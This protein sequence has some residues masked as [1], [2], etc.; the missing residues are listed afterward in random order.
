MIKKQSGID[1]S[2]TGKLSLSSRTDCKSVS[3]TAHKSAGTFKFKLGNGMVLKVA[4]TDKTL[5]EAGAPG[6]VIGLEQRGKF[7]ASYSLDAKKISGNIE[8]KT[9]LFDKDVV[10]K[11]GYDQK[12]SAATVD[13]TWSLNNVADKANIKHN[14]TKGTTDAKLT[15]KKNDMTLE[16][17]FS[18]PANS[19]GV[20]ASKKLKKADMKLSYNS[21]KVAQIEWIKSPFNVTIKGT[22]PSDGF[23]ADLACS[24]EKTWDL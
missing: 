15:F 19:W 6:G 23:K 24:C 22:V 21:Q 3:N 7:S 18:Y 2:F 4:G 11:L 9:T 12:S 16:P 1:G 20:T 5:T 14:L 10:L 13:T 8:T 17:S